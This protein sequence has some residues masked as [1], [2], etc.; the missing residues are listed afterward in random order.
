MNIYVYNYKG[1]SQHVCWYPERMRTAT[2]RRHHLAAI[3][4]SALSPAHHIKSHQITSHH[5]TST[6]NHT[7]LPPRVTI[8]KSLLPQTRGGSAGAGARS[9][10]A[11]DC[12]LGRATRSGRPGHPGVPSAEMYTRR[13]GQ[14]PQTTRASLDLK[15][16]C[17]LRCLYN[18]CRGHAQV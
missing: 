5:I 14:Y 17:C 4:R 10:S 1:I 13:L 16:V 18:E 2:T 8:S 3:H 7:S 9:P 11:M 15:F 6:A 12:A